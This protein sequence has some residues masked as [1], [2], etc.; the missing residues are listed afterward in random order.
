MSIERYMKRICSR[1]TAVYWGEPTKDAKAA[2]LYATPVE[3]GCFWK[4]EMEMIRDSK[5]REIVSRA[6]VYVTQDLDEHGMLF[7]GTLA[8]LSQ[9]EESDPRIIPGAYEV[10]MF[11][12]IPS[13]HLP[14]EYNRNAV[15]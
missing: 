2:L 14:N 6:K 3:I 4:E 13:L 11:L 9:D 10:K 1:D 12:K 8:D 15:L 5:G 7:H